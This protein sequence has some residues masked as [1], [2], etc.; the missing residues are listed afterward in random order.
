MEKANLLMLSHHYLTFVK[1]Q[2]DV[3]S[4]YFNHVYVLVRCNPIAELSNYLP[5]NYLKPF[6]RKV[7]IDSTNKPENVTVIPTNV[8]YFPTDNQYKK[9]GDRHF[10]A[11]D[12]I[13]KKNKIEFNLIHSH[14][15]WTAGYVGTRLK[16][17]YN[18]PVVVTA[19]GYDIYD[20]PFKDGEWREK[21]KYVLNSADYIITVSNSN[22]EF[23]KKLKVK[24]PVKVIPNGFRSDLFYPRD[25]SE[26]KKILNLPTDKKIILTVG[27]L[28]EMKGH[29]YLIEAMKKVIKRRKD[30]LC[31]IVG[32]G[33]LKNKLKNQ[34]KKLE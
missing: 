24:T 3:L 17:K 14:F 9:L 1:D 26:C 12:K 32:G 28:L 31:I 11:V 16:E 25:L 27:N 5:I 22:L 6:R 13:I 34:I 20:L 15:T 7:I 4:K 23:I 29:K 19:H 30:V 18:I 10:K 2:V 8:P 21:I 33:K